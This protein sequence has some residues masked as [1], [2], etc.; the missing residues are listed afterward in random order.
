MN[1][2]RKR[3]KQ[4]KKKPDGTKIALWVLV[5]LLAAGGTVFGA[6]MGVRA[7]RS[8]VLDSGSAFRNDVIL[9]SEHH[10]LNAAMF[11]YRFYDVFYNEGLQTGY[12][13]PEQLK[14]VASLYEG[15]S[16]YE[17]DR[18]ILLSSLES[19]LRY[20]EAATKR[21]VEL[22]EYDVQAVENAVKVIENEAKTAGTPVE[23][24]IFS[25]YGRGVNTDDIKALL[26]LE[27]LAEKERQHTEASLN[28][29]DEEIARTVSSFAPEKYLRFDYYI[30]DLDPSDPTDR[31]EE[32]E[33]KRETARQNAVRL[34]S[35]AT[36]E[37][38]RALAQAYMKQLY[39]TDPDVTEE[40]F[41]ETFEADCHF[42]GRSYFELPEDAPQTTRWL[43]S[44]ERKAGDRYL[45]EEEGTVYYIE[46][47]AYSVD[48]RDAA[49]RVIGVPYADYASKSD[50]LDVFN[51][52]T[53]DYEKRGGGEDVF[54]AL[55]ELYEHGEAAKTSGGFYDNIYADSAFNRLIEERRAQLL[56][57]GG[58][59]EK[60]KAYELYGSVG[61]YLLY[62]TGSGDTRSVVEARDALITKKFNAAYEELKKTVTVTYRDEE[63]DRIAPRYDRT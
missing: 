54:I 56:E 34:A 16:L 33:A 59:F 19:T 50:A 55:T 41:D 3:K 2:Q 61:V 45:D 15:I 21:G 7:I 24:Y 25:R 17:Y 63:G 27:R 13:D 43:F 48:T 36:D 58:D 31:S 18:Q 62:C 49:F 10:T 11:S 53:S 47:G 26:R 40:N 44:T 30:V 6:V 8:A 42:T 29:T 37:E 9:Q 23:D 28:V 1:D 57:E 60:G 14:N 4:Q 39:A 12:D 46:R 52:L 32:T 5:A 22:D 20:A 38:F 35:A 51:R